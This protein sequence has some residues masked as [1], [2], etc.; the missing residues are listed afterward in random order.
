MT[1]MVLWREWLGQERIG[2]NGDRVV[3]IQRNDRGT[4]RSQVREGKELM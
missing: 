3:N 1:N 2:V 4:E